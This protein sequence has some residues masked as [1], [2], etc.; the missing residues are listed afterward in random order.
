M[1][2]A[3]EDVRVIIVYKYVEYLC[4][5]VSEGK[6]YFNVLLDLFAKNMSN[7]F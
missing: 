3:V 4:T 1:Q 7:I 5:P 2:Y 6:K